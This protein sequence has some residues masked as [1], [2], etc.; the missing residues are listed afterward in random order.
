MLSAAT[1]GCRWSRAFSAGGL[2]LKVI[3]VPHRSWYLLKQPIDTSYLFISSVFRNS[4]TPFPPVI[5]SHRGS[6]DC[7]TSR[8]KWKKEQQTRSRLMNS[9][10]AR[11]FSLV[12]GRPTA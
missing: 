4:F 3:K 12:D 5:R 7:P 1:D 9:A 8:S 2:H 10:T 11:M 6:S